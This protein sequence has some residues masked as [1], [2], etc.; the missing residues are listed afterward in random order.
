MGLSTQGRLGL[1]NI[2]ITREMN[3]YLENQGENSDFNVICSCIL[4]FC[5]K[6][7]SPLGFYTGVIVPMGSTGLNEKEYFVHSPKKNTRGL[8]LKGLYTYV[9]VNLNQKNLSGFNTFQSM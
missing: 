1:L 4:S 7:A 2:V 9:N 6:G 3:L 8:P 5:L